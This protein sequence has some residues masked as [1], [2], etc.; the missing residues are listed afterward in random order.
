MNELN[1]NIVYVVVRFLYDVKFHSI[2][3]STMNSILMTKNFIVNTF[4]IKIDW[5]RLIFRGKIF[6]DIET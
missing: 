6:N 4:T 2:K 5:Q 3:F 1:S